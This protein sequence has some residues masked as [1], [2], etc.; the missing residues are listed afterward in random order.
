MRVEIK[1]KENLIDSELEEL[2][3]FKEAVY[4]P[5]TRSAEA[6]QIEWSDSMWTVFI[7]DDNDKLVSY[8]GLITRDAKFD[9]DSFFIGGIGGV[10]THPDARRQG[11]AGFGLKKSAEVLRNELKVDFSLLVC[12]DELIP[13]YQK[14]GWIHFKGDMMVDQSSGKTKF[15]F[16]KP[17]LLEG[18]KPIPQCDTIDLCGKPW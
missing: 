3:V 11:Y 16:N 14:F 2:R 17:M 10:A 4:P 12:R 13:Y 15:T 6:L 8:M 18:I 5:D 9:G 7:R 1:Q